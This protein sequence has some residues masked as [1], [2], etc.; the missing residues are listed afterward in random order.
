MK[1]LQLEAKTKKLQKAMKNSL[2]KLV[3]KYKETEE[4]KRE[5]DSDDESPKKK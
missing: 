3:V 2:D 5:K 1:G 4:A